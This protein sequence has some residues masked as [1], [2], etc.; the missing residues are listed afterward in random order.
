MGMMGKNNR[1]EQWG[2][3]TG[4]AGMTDDG[5][6]KDSGDGD[7][8]EGCKPTALG[9]LLNPTWMTLEN[10]KHHNIIRQPAGALMHNINNT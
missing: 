5:D 9:W 7:G 3:T 1:N 8:H 10:T 4:T 6:N 2:Q